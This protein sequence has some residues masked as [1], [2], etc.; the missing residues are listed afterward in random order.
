MFPLT[1]EDTCELCL[2]KRWY[3][4]APQQFG[5]ILT[6]VTDRPTPTDSVFV[7]LLKYLSRPRSITPVCVHVHVSYRY[8]LSHFN[9]F[10]ARLSH[11]YRYRSNEGQADQQKMS[12]HLELP[13]PIIPS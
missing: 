10:R 1:E 7:H 12:F 3:V 11:Y 13:A 9:C 5:Y 8:I 2:T 4:P 6:K